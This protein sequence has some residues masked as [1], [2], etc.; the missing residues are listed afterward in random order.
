MLTHNMLVKQN[1][2][3]HLTH[4]YMFLFVN[5]TH[6][7]NKVLTLF[8]SYVNAHLNMQCILLS[9]KKNMLLLHILMHYAITCVCVL[10][11]LDQHLFAIPCYI[12]HV[13]VYIIIY[14]FA[15]S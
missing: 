11:L 4:A 10:T 13:N 8:S 14:Y 6:L 2:F 5:T 3:Q 1:M 15:L 7:T 9:N 12:L